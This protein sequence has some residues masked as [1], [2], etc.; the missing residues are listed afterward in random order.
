MIGLFFLQYQRVSL[1]GLRHCVLQS[2]M[3][4]TSNCQT[5]VKKER[6]LLVYLSI[7]DAS[8]INSDQQ[9]LLSEEEL[10]QVSEWLKLNSTG[11]LKERKER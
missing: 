1:C 5:W 9:E 3:K 6:N 2:W 11:R 10:F 8:L 7:S 4:K